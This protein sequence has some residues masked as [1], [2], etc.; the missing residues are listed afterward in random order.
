MFLTQ[1]KLQHLNS[2]VHEGKVV[3]VATDADG[4][5]WYTV[6]QD[7]YED[8]YI[9]QSEEERTGWEEWQELQF[10]GW[11]EAQTTDDDEPQEVFVDQ[12][13]VDKE[14]EELTYD[15][16]GETKYLH[17]SQYDSYAI[18]AVAPVQL[19]S[20]MGN[21][22][23]FRQS[24]DNTLL[25]DRFVLDG[26]LNQLVP[27]LEVRYKRSRYKYEPLTPAEGEQRFDSL[28]FNDVY[29]NAFYE[30]TTEL[31]LITNLDNGWF[32]VILVPTNELDVYRWHIFAY[33]SS[34]QKVELTTIRASEEGLFDTKDYLVLEPNPDNPDVLRPRTIPGVIRRTLDLGD[35][36]ISNG[37]A[38][39]VYNL[40]YEQQT[41]EG[42]TQLLKGDTR[43]MLAI[44][45]SKDKTTNLAASLS[46][47]VATDGTL[48]QIEEAANSETVLRGNERDMLLPLN[49][50][51]EIRAIGETEPPPQGT[52]SKLERG[53]EDCVQITSSETNGLGKGDTVEIKNSQSYDQLYQSVTTVDKDTF[54]VELESTPTN[55]GDWEVVPEKET[56]LVF[57][58]LITAYEITHDGKI[59]VTAFNHG[60][61]TG[62]SVQL[63]G[64]PDYD[65]TYAVTP[66]E[67]GSGFTLNDLTWTVGEAAN[68]KLKSQK[69]RGIV[70]DGKKD[71]INFGQKSEF[72]VNKE[73]TLEAWIYATAQA[74]Y[75]GI[76]SNI[77]DTGNT[78][79][80]YA[81]TLD[82]TSGVYFGLKV[83]DTGIEYLSSG[84]NTIKLNQ[85][86]H[87]AA[88]YDG[89]TMR[90]YVDGVEKSSTDIPASS[91]DYDP[92][93]DL[94]IGTY[95]DDD[96]DTHF[97]G[98]IADVRIWKVARSAAD[99]KN[100][101][102]LQLTGQEVGLVGYWRL[103]G[104]VPDSEPV[105]V[106]FSVNGN[107]GKV[108]GDPFVSAMT[109]SRTLGDG[110]TQ[111]VK[112]INESLFAVTQ[113]AT[114]VETFE[115][116]RDDAHNTIDPNNVDGE[117]MFT[118]TY[119][120]KRSRSAE[121][122]I[123]ND[124]FFV[125][126]SDFQSLEN[127][128][129]LASCRFTVPDEVTL[130]RTFG[131]AN[132]TGD[133]DT[134][135]VRKNS[136]RLV[137]D[138]VTEANYTDSLTDLTT[139]AEGYTDSGAD[140][141][142]LN[143]Y[144]R[145][146]AILLAEKSQL[147]YQIDL[148]ESGN[149]DDEVAAKQ[150]EVDGL[151]QKR[152]DAENTYNDEKN[153][154]LNYWCHLKNGL[155][156]DTGYDDTCHLFAGTG[157]DDNANVDVHPLSRT[158]LDPDRFQWKFEH[159]EDEYYYLKNR[160]GEYMCRKSTSETEKKRNVV[161]DNKGGR[162]ASLFKWERHIYGDYYRFRNGGYYLYRDHP[163]NVM[164]EGLSNNLRFDWKPEPTDDTVNDNVANAKQGWDQAE[165][166]YNTANDEL[167]KL[168]NLQTDQD[169]ALEN[170]NTEL[171]QVNTALNQVQPS[172]KTLNTTLLGEVNDT[173]QTPQTLPDI[174]QDGRNLTT[175]GAILG[176]VQ[177]DSRISALETCEGMV[178]LSYVDQRGYMHQTQYDATADSNN[179]TFE[180]WLP[181]DSLRACLNVNQD[182][183]KVTLAQPVALSSNWTI[184][185]WFFYPL[186]LKEVSPEQ[187]WQD[188][189]QLE[190]RD[191][192]TL[193][194]SQSGSDR[195]IVVTHGKYLGTVVNGVF[196]ES[197]YSLT[198]LSVGWH[199]LTAVGVDADQ[200]Q[201]VTF[202]IDGASVG[203]VA[204]EPALGFDGQESYIELSK[205]LSSIQNAVTIE[206]WAKGGTDLPKATSVFHA[207]D[208]QQNRILNIHLPWSGGVIY[209]DAG[210]GDDPDRIEKQ[211]TTE[212]YQ[213]TWTHWAFVKD[214]SAETM[215]IYRNGNLWHQD[216]NKTQSLDGIHACIIGAC[217]EQTPPIYY[218]NG[219]LSE[220]RIWDSARTQN[221]IQANMGKSLTGTESGLVGYWKM[222]TG[223]DGTVPDYSSKGN[224]GT[225]HGTAQTGI[226]SAVSQSD[227]S[228]I[229]NVD[230]GS[231]P[232]G[233]LS[234]VRIWETALT[235]NEI[236]ANSKTLLSGNEPNLAAYY[237]LNEATG[238]DIRDHS[239]NSNHGTAT[240][241]SW[242]ACAA[243]IGN[244]VH[245]V[246]Q[247][248]GADD[249]IYC[250]SNL[251]LVEKSFTIELW[252]KRT[253][254]GADHFLIGYG[255]HQRTT[256]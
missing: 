6:K 14:A 53:E 109:L 17:R 80:G 202:Y 15:V 126:P 251:N 191:W 111:A 112:Y 32:S 22:Y 11:K 170:L 7:G 82:G 192:Y 139:L 102:Y 193:V 99:I 154:P 125:E 62:D 40:Q 74:K 200:G 159:I 238:T 41:Q 97:Q 12:S 90:V 223:S 186:P 178:Q 39:T 34:S 73:L 26:M 66:L 52:I 148:I 133:W 56:G 255:Q 243:P 134:M 199:H 213:G 145:E 131:I 140:L 114:Y 169:T 158:D 157:G 234:E 212:E 122:Y 2:I 104:I 29:G 220:F 31:S 88:T 107:D 143:E 236:V 51:D 187:D 120:G 100:A 198:R 163:S 211:A 116:K 149:L 162:D 87:V 203:Q 64:T 86:H 127:G 253:S 65:G 225:I 108:Y 5:I 129:Y 166:D 153:N 49:T 218:W 144:E 179:T 135:E 194:S 89:Q 16:D 58:G 247:F 248:D 137:S 59:Q 119:W 76:V 175:Q 151:D 124:Q 4:K 227:I 46:F 229:G 30:P 60:L 207:V 167:T 71:Y 190:Q 67:D 47:A 70:F 24:Q 240:G 10:P 235:E 252:A 50:L 61:E 69:R 95:K 176:F 150:Q 136:I 43:V 250:S 155:N 231:Q 249:S 242:W 75:S 106:D 13:V 171:D 241:T 230:A 246:M 228:T 93:N 205:P 146:E 63:L 226:L 142:Q 105:V 180:Q 33:N 182:S 173:Q 206:F 121:D 98:K 84:D 244:L 189:P 79:S 27:K 9:S 123:E 78:E 195:Q 44:P 83:P 128:W 20:G 85:W 221:Q 48:S 237:P 156:P 183:S 92:G 77:Y 18:S 256:C 161:T 38:A 239:P 208:D 217:N 222:D 117:K 57:D 214:V 45:T 185:A 233:K 152:K 72:Q 210:N 219:Q 254:S 81:L 204:S 37:L 196:F 19:V 130:V 28:D 36:I 141:D 147:Q 118:F 54:T 68:P 132:V 188:E 172:L 164:V 23:I 110:T 21:L 1:P 184:E 224:N 113:R 165:S 197:G 232:F 181:D 201:T 42:D 209:W 168:K 138:T 115:F 160:A 94:T 3:I 245:T 101:M 174:N 216:S 25:V 103:G 55:L 91:I 8:T 35:R 96:E 177:P 215:S